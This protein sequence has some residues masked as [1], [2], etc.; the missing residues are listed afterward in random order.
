MTAMVA[1]HESGLVT[2]CPRGKNKDRVLSNDFVVRRLEKLC[3]V[4]DISAKKTLS[5][6]IKF[7]LWEG[8]N[9]NKSGLA[10]FSQNNSYHIFGCQNITLPDNL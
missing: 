5:G 4:K 8:F 9:A 6:K 2:N 7:T 1:L 10:V 3:F